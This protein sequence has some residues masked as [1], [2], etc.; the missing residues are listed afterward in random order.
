MSRK[1]GFT[2]IELLVVITIIAILAAILFPVFSR[3]RE[4][5]RAASCAS[6]LKQIGL[7]AKMY[8]EDY[9]QVNVPAVVSTPGGTLSW[10]VLLKP[11][12]KNLQLFTCPSKARWVIANNAHSGGYVLAAVIKPTVGVTTP[13]T[14]W[15]DADYDDPSKTV[16]ALDAPYYATGQAGTNSGPVYV[17]NVDPTDVDNLRHFDGINILWYD[18]HVKW[19]RAE[20]IN[21]PAAGGGGC[22]YWTLEED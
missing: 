11:Y 7:A 20:K 12:H 17:S 15:H 16:F 14:G 21:C 19:M 10:A 22:R 4:K 2:L 9:D 5:A 3:A 13:S 18:G 1:S 8:L 6:N